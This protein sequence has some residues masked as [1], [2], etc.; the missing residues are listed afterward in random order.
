MFGVFVTFTYKQNFDESFIRQIAKNARAKFE[1]MPGLVSKTFTINQVAGE[2]TNF[3]VWDSEEKA[4]AFFNEELLSRVTALYG[5]RP[6]LTF[7]QI[8]ERVENG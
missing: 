6:T 7:V 4:R 1:S 5:I 2:A 3:Y 8:A